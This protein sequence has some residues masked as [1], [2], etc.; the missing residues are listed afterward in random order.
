MIS[1]SVL[2]SIQPVILSDENNPEIID[3]RNDAF[4]YWDI[5]NGWFQE[6]HMRKDLCCI[7]IMVHDLSP[8]V[9]SVCII[10]WKCKNIKYQVQVNITSFRVPKFSAKIFDTQWAHYKI[11]G[12]CNYE[13]NT[14]TFKFPKSEIGFL[15]QGDELSNISVRLF[16]PSCYFLNNNSLIYPL[17]NDN[18]TGRNYKIQY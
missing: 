12:N 5:I 13:D 14:I 3:Q 11:M 6:H 18:A 2:I 16:H 4:K 15:S 10:S 9:S 1:I 8:L 17:I 7:T